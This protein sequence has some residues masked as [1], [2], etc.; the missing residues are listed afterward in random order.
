M[1]RGKLENRV[2]E[3]KDVYK[4][5]MNTLEMKYEALKT[6]IN[7]LKEYID[8]NSLVDDTNTKEAIENILQLEKKINAELEE[9]SSKLFSECTNLKMKY[10]K[11]FLLKTKD[12]TSFANDKVTLVTSY[13]KEGDSDYPVVRK[14]FDTVEK[15]NKNNFVSL[16]K[17]IGENFTL[18]H[19]D[20]DQSDQ[21][22]NKFFETG[23]AMLNDIAKQS[24]Y[25]WVDEKK[26]REDFKIN[27]MAVMNEA[28]NTLNSS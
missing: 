7:K 18:I 16:K 17:N 24:D 26:K 14:K 21:L 2:K 9:D 6:H 25:G 13:I 27:V 1:Y 15:E 5:S 4:S 19:K 3:L 22:T 23:Y 8:G 11:D 28:V 10:Q 20:I 12:N